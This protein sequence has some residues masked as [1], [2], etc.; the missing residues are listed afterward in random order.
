MFSPK[1]VLLPN[2]SFTPTGVV[3]PT[4][5]FKTDI[6][7]EVEVSQYISKTDLVG[8]VSKTPKSL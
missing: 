2:E 1:A 8:L 3:T 5:A 4:S 7:S 6:K